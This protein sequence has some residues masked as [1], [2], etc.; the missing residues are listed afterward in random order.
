MTSIVT[1]VQISG[2]LGE[3]TLVV[4]ASGQVVFSF[5]LVKYYYILYQL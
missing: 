2:P 3:V 5:S 4:D 1:T